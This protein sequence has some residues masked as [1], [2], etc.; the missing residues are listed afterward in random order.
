[1]CVAIQAFP[2]PVPHGS[3]LEQQFDLLRRTVEENARAL[4]EARVELERARRD[5]WPD[6]ELSVAEAQTVAGLRRA[7]FEIRARTQ[8]VH[9][10]VQR[11]PRAG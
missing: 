4:A 8:E 11:L 6:R 9:A 1:M 7:R 5:E 10:L 3:R 2:D